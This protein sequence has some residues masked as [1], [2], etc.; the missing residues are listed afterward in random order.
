MKGDRKK[1]IRKIETIYTKL[2]Q[3][4]LNPDPST[5]N[6]PLPGGV[7]ERSEAE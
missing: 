3:K 2:R 7:A 5:D 1:A 6:L 4:S